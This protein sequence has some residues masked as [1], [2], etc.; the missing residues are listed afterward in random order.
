MSWENTYQQFKS[1]SNLDSIAANQMRQI[2]FENFVR[3]GLPTRKEE[4]WRYTSLNDFSAI[5]WQSSNYEEESLTHDQMVAVS[6]NLP[7]EF[8]NI[9]VVNG[10]VN[11]TLSDDLDGDITIGEI[12]A[13]DLKNTEK[14]VEGHLLQLSKSFLSKKIMIEVK[15]HK[16]FAKPL[17]LVI[18]QSSKTSVYLSEK[19]SVKIGENAELTLVVNT[20]SFANGLADALNIN[21]DLEIAD[22][23][24]VKMIQLQNEDTKSFHFSQVEVNLA[25]KAEFQSLAMSLGSKLTRNYFHLNFLGKNSS[26][27]VFGLTLLDSDQ[28]VDNYTFIQHS[29]GENQSVQHY[30]SI[31]AG[32]SQSVFRGRVRIEPDAQK[33]N[34]AQL[35]NNLLLTREAFATS[36]PQLEIYADD[37]KAGHGSTMGQLNK[38]EIFYFLSRGINQ[39]EAVKMLSFGYAKELIYKFENQ[40]VQDFLLKSVQSKLERMIQNV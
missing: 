32:S 4:A 34:S 25:S 20:F 37:V 18:V 21:V 38:E 5:T 23:A 19:V 29:F 9:V 35:N 1:K 10:I 30:K 16:T 28:H 12:V 40:A 13:E 14:H 33:A 39:F 15:S 26:A 7:A 22:S 3:E 6:K 27:Q 24:R 36:I 2:S 31:L 17:Q 8:Y 11:A